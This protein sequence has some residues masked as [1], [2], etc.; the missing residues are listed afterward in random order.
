[1][2]LN[3]KTSGFNLTPN[4]QDYLNKKIG[5]L[6]KFIAAQYKEAVKIDV[7]VSRDTFHHK[8]GDVFEA[9]I[10]LVMPRGDIYAIEKSQDIF[11]A[12]DLLEAKVKHELISRRSKRRDLLIKSLRQL[13]KLL[14]LPK[15]WKKM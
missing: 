7:E 3:I 2:H 13:K 9:K 1:M 14:R 12:I 15:F 8:K 11:S 10:H 4:I 5:A 6:E